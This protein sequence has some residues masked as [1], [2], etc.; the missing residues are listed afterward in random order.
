MDRPGPAGPCPPP[1]GRPH[2]QARAAQVKEAATAKR[3]RREMHS[4]PMP[5]SKPPC[6]ATARSWPTAPAG[7]GRTQCDSLC[8]APGPVACRRWGPVCQPGASPLRSQAGT[9]PA[10][11]ASTLWPARLADSPRVSSYWCPFVV[12]THSTVHPEGDT[13]MPHTIRKNAREWQRLWRGGDIITEIAG[14]DPGMPR[15]APRE[16]KALARPLG[17]HGRTS[18]AAPK[19]PRQ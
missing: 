1:R 5:A 6:V 17:L 8:A 18:T 16:R 13:P 10:G 11:P 14:D 7:D 9:P 19:E 3:P 15:R 12:R 4:P 2:G